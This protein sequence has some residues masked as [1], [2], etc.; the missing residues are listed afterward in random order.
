MIK[1]VGKV[2]HSFYR[3]FFTDRKTE[4]CQGFIDGDL[5]ENF[6]DLSREKMEEVC[7]GLK[8]RKSRWRKYAL[9]QRRQGLDGGG[10]LWAKGQA[11]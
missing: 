3:S 8:V 9:G 11:G 2:S 7:S 5:V 6:L 1:S 4:K 10:V